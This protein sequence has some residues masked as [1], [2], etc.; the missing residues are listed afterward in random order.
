VL[1]GAIL[2]VAISYFPDVVRFFGGDT[3]TASSVSQPIAKKPA[4]E[5]QTPPD[6]TTALAA[7]RKLTK[8]IENGDEETA[9][10]YVNNARWNEIEL[11][12]DEPSAI[13]EL[14]PQCD[15]EKKFESQDMDDRAV[16]TAKSKPIKDPD[17]QPSFTVLTV[18]MAIEDEQWKVFSTSCNYRPPSDY[19]EEA[20][21]WLFEQPAVTGDDLNSKLIANG[22]P[23][24]EISCFMAVERGHPKAVKRC[25]ETGWSVDAENSDGR[26]AIDIAF[27]KMEYA[28]PENNE[29]IELFVKEGANID[30]PNN[31][32]M[33]PLMLAAIHCDGDA[34][35]VFIDAGADIDYKSAN[36]ITPSKLAENCPQVTKLLR[37][38]KAR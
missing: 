17:G 1:I 34:A 37:A 13:K 31:E 21:V 9:K 30:R 29:V 6:Q 23:D 25:L 35:K 11:E 18:N 4:I 36:G 2:S 38:A 5:E 3:K 26:K 16:L 28:S 15:V 8:A 19:M 10:S 33:T 7:Y 22:L 12:Q 14:K 27:A 32:G 24:G 20:R